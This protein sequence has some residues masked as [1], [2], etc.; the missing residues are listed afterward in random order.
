MKRKKT[1]ALL[2][3]IALVLCT[4]LTAC[5]NS[6]SG[7]NNNSSTTGENSGGSETSSGAEEDASGAVQD[8][9]EVTLL[10]YAFGNGTNEEQNEAVAAEISAYC[11][12]KI[13]ANVEIRFSY[14]DYASQMTALD[15][16]G[17]P[18]DICWCSSWFNNYINNANSGAYMAIEDML[19]VYAPR[20][21]S[22][23]LNESF[24]DAVTLNGHIYGVPIKLNSARESVWV[25]PE[26]YAEKYNFDVTKVETLSDFHDY[27]TAIKDDLGS[28]PAFSVA[29]TRYL[30]EYYV[31]LFDGA[32]CVGY[33]RN[34][35]PA[36][37]VSI[38][39]VWD[40][41]YMRDYVKTMYEFNQEGLVRPYGKAEAD[42]TEFSAI[43]NAT[44]SPGMETSFLRN[45]VPLCEDVYSSVRI[46]INGKGLLTTGGV[47]QAMNAISA[48]SKN[49][50]RAL[51]F[52][53]LVNTDEYLYNLMAYGIEGVNYTL[54]ENQTV[55]M[56]SS[57]PYQWAGY[58]IGNYELAYL[59]S[60]NADLTLKE[61]TKEWMD[62]AD[63]SPLMGFVPD[64]SSITMELTN[65]S[66]V[67]NEYLIGTENGNGIFMHGQKSFEDG[68]T[69]FMK[70]LET[71][72]IQK[73]IEEMQRQV[74]EWLAG[75]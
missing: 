34:D 66:T 16:S 10:I 37:G 58:G 27:L 41:D 47:Q 64:S 67:V 1:A 48:N 50:E 69:E 9:D 45:N 15:G 29:P 49:P 4:C 13:N 36:D 51:M 30:Q 24:W 75:K 72:G 3:A 53:E 57:N 46:K 7:A 63:S 17:E 35:D 73:V 70:K 5:S 52:L 65:I 11:K 12:E 26:E 71:A 74:D 25:V 61:K 44:Y 18:Y 22:E 19:P 20:L 21:Y 33:E 55:T 38:I 2:L 23:V 6:A 40:N 28:V 68:Y 39:N 42:F 43:L 31:D 56:N 54:E 32:S 8:L 14:G 59:S 60:S 62:N